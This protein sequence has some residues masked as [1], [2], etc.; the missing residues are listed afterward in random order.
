MVQDRVRNRRGRGARGGGV[1]LVS[2]VTEDPICLSP[3]PGVWLALG[4]HG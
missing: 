1:Q 4:G 2:C 3:R